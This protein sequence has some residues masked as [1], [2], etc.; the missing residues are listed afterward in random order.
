MRLETLAVHGGTRID[1]V[2]RAVTAPIHLST[3][4]EPSPEYEAHDPYVYSRID[5]P[6]RSALETL[7]DPQVKITEVLAVGALVH[8]NVAGCEVVRTCA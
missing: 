2:T 5:N 6:N 7:L 8:S 3:T 4:F 1:P